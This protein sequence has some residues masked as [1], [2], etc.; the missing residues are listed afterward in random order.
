MP[1][2]PLSAPHYSLKDDVY[3]GYRIAAGTTVIPNIWAIHHNADLYPEPFAFEPERF[4]L[5][6]EDVRAE[7][8]NE[9]HYAFGFGRR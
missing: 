8:L 4:L 5:A 1:V 2:A 7:L 6:R 9:G 3:K